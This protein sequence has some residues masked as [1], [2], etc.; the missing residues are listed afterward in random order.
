V[1]FLAFDEDLAVAFLDLP[2]GKRA[3][4]RSSY[5]FTRLEAETR[6][7]PWTAH[8]GADQQTVG[9]RT[10]IVRT[11]R[12]QREQFA[13]LTDEKH[14]VVANMTGH[15]GAVPEIACRNATGEI[16]SSWFLIA[17]CHCFL[18]T[19]PGCQPG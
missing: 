4:G 14:L 15:H 11:V 17:A 10:V 16:G 9:K 3:Q 5:C 18:R 13:V 1:G 6:V 2:A 12:G 7:M 19:L 8:C